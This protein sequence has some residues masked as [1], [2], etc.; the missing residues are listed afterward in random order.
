MITDKKNSIKNK[1]HPNPL[2]EEWLEKMN[3]GAKNMAN[4]ENV[5]NDLQMNI[6]IKCIRN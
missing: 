4:D 1:P 3:Q 6:Q 5:Q 2:I